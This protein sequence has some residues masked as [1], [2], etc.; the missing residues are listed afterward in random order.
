M[1]CIYNLHLFF[2]S[3]QVEHVTSIKKEVWQTKIRT[4]EPFVLYR[5]QAFSK[6]TQ[7]RQIDLKRSKDILSF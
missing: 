7:G 2:L 5:T 3:F 4:L 1:K 6:T